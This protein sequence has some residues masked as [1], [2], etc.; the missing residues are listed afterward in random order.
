LEKL[1]GTP[2]AEYKVAD[3]LSLNVPYFYHFP[4]KRHLYDGHGKNI[5]KFLLKQQWKD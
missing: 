2:Y 3:L 5:Q 4:G 1:A